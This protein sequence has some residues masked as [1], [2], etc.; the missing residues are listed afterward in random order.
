MDIPMNSLDQDATSIGDTLKKCHLCGK[1]DFGPITG[2]SFAHVS[3]FQ[4]IPKFLWPSPDVSVWRCPECG[5][6]QNNSRR[7]AR[8]A[9]RN[10]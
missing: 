10:T 2:W 3:N 1:E 7:Q 5:I 6:L 8:A 9:L 4:D